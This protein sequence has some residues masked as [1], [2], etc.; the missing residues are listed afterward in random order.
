MKSRSDLK[1]YPK[2]YMLINCPA[3][4]PNCR[5]N[6]NRNVEFCFEKEKFP[7]C[8]YPMREVPDAKGVLG[9]SHKIENQTVI[10]AIKLQY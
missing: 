3:F 8:A 1:D 4:S 7:N 2:F 6:C 9:K 5:N 10:L